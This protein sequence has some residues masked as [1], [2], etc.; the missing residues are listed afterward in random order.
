MNS[1]LLL[2]LYAACVAWW[3]PVPLRRLTV[4]GVSP[5]LGLAAWL[6]AMAS[7]LVSAGVALTIVTRAAIG[8][9]LCLARRFCTFGLMMS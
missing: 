7:V 4:S 3:A 9:V 5:R 1:A 8:R 2:F 6:I